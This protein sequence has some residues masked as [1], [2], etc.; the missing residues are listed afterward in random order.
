MVQFGINYSTINGAK[1][2]WIFQHC[3]TRETYLKISILMRRLLMLAVITELN[4]N[5]VIVIVCTNNDSLTCRARNKDYPDHTVIFL[6]I[7]RIPVS[8]Q[9]Y[10]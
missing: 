6:Q 4:Y 2:L 8:S 3:G 7:D 10:N 1:K 9:N 5:A